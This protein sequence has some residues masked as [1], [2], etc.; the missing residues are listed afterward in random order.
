[1]FKNQK[2]FIAL[3]TFDGLHTGHKKVLTAS[4]GEFDKKIAL[5]FKTHP[6]KIICGK[7]PGELITPS[8]RE[9][10][11][12][13]WGLT[14]EYIDFESISELSPSDFAEKILINKYGATAL[15][16]GFNYRFGKNAVGDA[17][18]LKEICI[19]NGITLTVCDEVDFDGLPIS[20]TRI[21]EALRSGDIRLANKM[22]GRYFSYDF[23]VVHGDARGR[24]LGSPT[25]NQFFT[26]DFTVPQYGVYA[27]FAIID[28]EK[29]A[30]VT[31]IGVRP[32]IGNS[33][34][35]SETNIIGYDGDLYGKHTEVCL[36]EKLRDEMN[37]SSLEEL[38]KQISLDRAASAEIIKNEG[39]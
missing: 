38:G 30:A 9:R 39:V 33:E 22:L 28:G 15:C 26:E 14:P 10:L 12:N 25:I 13:S 29:Y 3:G 6:Q 24:I 7:T 8:K 34:K 23:E 21:R 11:L 2:V 37:F 17:E 32:T 18:L 4:E 1:M 19:E 16:C 36:V 27:S 31:N 5:M 20:S 35:R